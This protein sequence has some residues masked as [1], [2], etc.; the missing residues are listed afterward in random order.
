MQDSR[1]PLA[2][3]IAGRLL[4]APLRHSLTTWRRQ[5]AEQAAIRAAARA[6]MVPP[7]FMW[8]TVGAPDNAFVEQGRA[9]SE[10][11]IEH[12][13][14]RPD[15]A[16]LDIGCGLGKYALHLAPF[17]QHGG[18]LEGFDVERPSI[19]WC[20]L[21]ITPRH[22]H[23]QFRHTPLKSD[24]YSPQATASAASFSYPYGS[25]AFDLAFLAS[26]FTHMLTEDVDNYI[27]EIARVLKPGGRCIATMYLLNDEK[28]AG[29]A[30]GTAAFTF[31]IPRA[32]CWIERPD[33]PEAAVA[34]DE[35]AVVAMFERA[36]LHLAEPI[37]YGCWAAEGHQDQDFLVLEKREAA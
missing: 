19:D 5:A 21:A 22:P 26:V 9:F 30:A 18:R 16:V 11:L 8:G 1:R 2:R 32:G 15:S 23:A 20:Q 12:G 17:L 27:R 3:R 25:S 36:G 13:Q 28:R 29:I 7:P 4:P 33:P 31:P 24:M 34:Y 14:L 37:R 35:P 6:G 10:Y